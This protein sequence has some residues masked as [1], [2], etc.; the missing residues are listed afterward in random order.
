VGF[1][2]SGADKKLFGDLGGSPALRDE[3]QHDTFL[4][5]EYVLSVHWLPP[6]SD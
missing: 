1:N 3:R 4:F 2:G 6:H 5:R